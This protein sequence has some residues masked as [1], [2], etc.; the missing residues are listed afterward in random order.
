MKSSW[1]RRLIL[2]VLTVLAGPWLI[3]LA[4][5]A[6]SAPCDPATACFDVGLK[7]A[8]LL[9]DFYLD[10]VLV[11]SGVASARLTGAPDA[12]HLIEARNIQDPTTPG[13]ND[14][15]NYPDQRVTQ[16]TRAGWTWLVAFYPQKNYLK[17]TLTYICNP[18]NWSVGEALACRPTIDGVSQSDVAP[19]ASAAYFLASG[20]HVVHTDLVGEAAGNWNTTTRDDNV[21]VAAARTGYLTVTFSR[22]GQLQINVLPA[23]VLADLYV[24]GAP[25]A[26][27]AGSASLFVGSGVVHTVEARNVTDPAANGR[28]AYNDA[29]NTAIVYAGRTG[30]VYLRPVKVWLTGTL[31][32]TCL[33]NRKAATDDV[34]CLV[35]ADGGTLG[36]IPAGG[37]A[38]FTLPNGPHT[39]TVAAAG[40]SAGKWD[41]PVSAA[42]AIRGGFN[43]YYTARFNLRPN[44]PPPIP[45]TQPGPPVAPAPGPVSGAP[46]S[47][48]L[49]GQ[50]DSFAYP[51]QMRYAGMAW[52]KRQM[53]WSP[54]DQPDAGMI[55]EA[56]AKGFKILIALVGSPDDVAG[57]ANYDSY[58]AYAGQ[59]AALG[60]DAIEVWNETNLDRSW[61]RGEIDPA[62]YTDLLRRAYAQIK[63]NNPNTLVISSAPSPTG[64]E[65]AFGLDRVWND[66]RY[67]RGMAA[68]GAANYADCI[69]VHYNEG[70]IS[71][72]QASGD[73]RDPYYTR[74][75]PGMVSTYYNAFGGRRK[76]C[77]TELGYL[78]P[79]GYG[80]L[81]GLF[82]W[83]GDT[84]VAEQAQWLAE[85]VSLAQ[86]SQVVRMIIIF[87]VDFTV[88][89]DDP[90]GGYAI[91]R[92]GGG[93]PACE[94]LH[95][96]TG[97][98]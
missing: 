85:V 37:R 58:A 66:D 61:P 46:G 24:D 82:G 76:L 4:R 50:V 84:S 90:Q 41:G 21:T 47:F 35:S 9:G 87:N 63:A 88:Y 16:Q 44:T 11:A 55:E 40:A 42:V 34:S 1:K 69:G 95:A 91:M 64:A 53:Y 25:V 77:F 36:A 83:A 17:G 56:H 45:A 89:D 52:V 31:N 80:P 74:Y 75:Y 67:V 98:R 29:R 49:G 39:V 5:A 79:E 12:P 72:T 10:G 18:A 86:R 97:G 3:G 33:I 93:C 7:P 43:S 48:E 62:K 22:K 27:Q 30:L 70:I 14:L 68:A 57:A 51:D 23:G 20:G 81:P 26:G 71:P 6:D 8:T 54:G 59:V 92:P 19:G 32:V 13:F 15:F 73:P 78:S 65:G 2:A 60:A 96:V 28:Y 94:T 38:A